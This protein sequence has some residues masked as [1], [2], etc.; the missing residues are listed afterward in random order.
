MRVVLKVWSSNPDY[1]AGCDYAVVELPEEVAKVILRRINVLGEQKAL[2]PSICET[3]YWDSS[4]QYFSPW[5]NRA[6]ESEEIQA[7]C[8][9][10]E[11]TLEE[12][13][14][15]TCEV[16]SAPANFH[17]LESQIATVECAQMIMREEGIAFNALLKYTD[18]YVT[19]AEIPKQVLESGLTTAAA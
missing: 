12:L 3:Y 4:A 10:L 9:E 19:T 16:V 17:V 18:I 1:S 7:A 6:S 2:D 13:Q 11:E 5:V 8:S 14:V 15:D